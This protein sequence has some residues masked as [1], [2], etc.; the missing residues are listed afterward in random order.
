MS[1]SE[2]IPVIICIAKLES[3]YIEEFVKYHLAIGFSHIFIYDNEEEP[4][5]EKLLN[6][7]SANITVSH[8]PIKYQQMNVYNDF[9]KN[10]LFNSNIT[11]VACIDIDEFIVLK[12]HNNIKD[13]IKQF[14]VDDCEGIGMNWRFFGSSG[15]IEANVKEPLTKRF[16]LCEKNGNMHIK[17]LFKKDNFI[18]F[19]TMHDVILSNG[20]IKNTKGDIIIGPFN[21]NIDY[22]YIQLNH[23]KCKTLEE[24]KYIRTRGQADRFVIEP[25]PVTNFVHYDLNEIEDLTAHNFYSKLD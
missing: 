24:F 15:K 18:S 20:H 9:I 2:I 11:H 10:V 7:Y 23:Y 1:N 13:F 19:N 21:H 4:T 25:D 3:N 5:Y 17:T 12:Q 22:S 6:K 8:I 16:T 14:I